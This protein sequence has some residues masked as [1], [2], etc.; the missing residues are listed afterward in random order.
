MCY[1]S[2]SG[3][4]SSICGS[5]GKDRAG[6]CNA[7]FIARVGSAQFESG[8]L[9]QT[10]TGLTTAVHSVRAY[11]V[12]SVCWHRY[13]DRLEQSLIDCCAEFGVAAARCEHT[14]VWVGE[15]KVAAIGVQVSHGITW[16]G[17]ALN[18]DVDLAWFDHIVPCGIPDRGV[19]LT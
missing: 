6:A 10:A 19:S 1:S 4:P 15:R 14:G 12:S 16:H 5:C 9:Q 7:I 2:S 11:N 18:C 13:I 8:H 17:F 3:T